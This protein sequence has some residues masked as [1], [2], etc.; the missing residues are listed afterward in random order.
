MYGTIVVG[1]DGSP[2]S[3]LAVRRAAAIAAKFDSKLVLASAYYANATEAVSNRE[4]S[5][6]IVGEPVAEEVLAAAALEANKEG[7]R[8]IQ[9][10]MKAGSPVVALMGIVKEAEADLLVVGNRGIN[11]LTGRLLGSVPADVAR[12]S[13]CDVMIVHTAT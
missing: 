11:S 1:T 3:F 2:S 7:V 13:Q 6:T 9:A 4:D 10:V 8:D 5:E 12:Q